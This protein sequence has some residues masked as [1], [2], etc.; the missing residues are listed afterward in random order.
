MDASLY[1]LGRRIICF[2]CTISIRLSILVQSK[3]C[4]LAI[5]LN[6]STPLGV[7]L[8]LW[9]KVL[10]PCLTSHHERIGCWRPVDLSSYGSALSR[11]RNF[12]GLGYRKTPI[13]IYGTWLGYPL[14][15]T[16]LRT[17]LIRTDIDCLVD[18]KIW[19][20]VGNCRTWRFALSRQVW[21]VKM[22]VDMLC[23]THHGRHGPGQ[24]HYIWSRL[25]MPHMPP[26]E[27]NGRFENLCEKL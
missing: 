20:S 15:L 23:Y 27:T 8:S 17:R 14:A 26:S 12:R 7:V 1:Y 5:P 10:I 13:V 9:L 25:Y 4:N 18:K 24:P 3:E 6:K 21:A 22:Y 16:V 11:S 2:T 19:R